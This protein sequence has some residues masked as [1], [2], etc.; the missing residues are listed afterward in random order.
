MEYLLSLLIAMNTRTVTIENPVQLDLTQEECVYREGNLP[1][2]NNNPLNIT[3]GG[4]TKKW[5]D[6]GKA[7]INTTKDGRKFLKF[8]RVEDGF[9]A[10]RMLL[11]DVY[12]DM[13]PE[14]AMRKFSNGGYGALHNKKISEMTDDE[15][16]DFVEAIATREGFY[17]ES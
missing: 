15:F 10:G 17:N 6:Y 12:G 13:T 1:I 2:R 7:E 16:D 5:V 11:K 3:Y 8:C 14:S 9:D 4:A